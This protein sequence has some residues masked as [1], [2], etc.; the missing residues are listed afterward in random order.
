MKQR[1]G[2]MNNFENT[3][4]LCLDVRHLKTFFPVYKGS[5]FKRKMGEIKAVN[6][7]SFQIKRAK[8]M[9]M[10]GESGCGKTTVGRSILLLNRPTSGEIIYNGI[11]IMALNYQEIR[12]L[13]KKIQMVFQD[14]FGSINPRMTAGDVIGEPL[15]IHHICQT[16]YEYQKTIAELFLMVGLDPG[17]ADWYPHE[18]S[19]GQRQ[20]IVI[21]RALSVK[22][23]LLICDEPVSALDVSIQAQI[24]N[25]LEELQEKYHLTY[26]FI[27]HDLSVVKHISDTIAVMY[28][29]N[30]VEIAH[31]KEL[32]DHPRHPYTRALFSSVP[33]PDPR[34]EA[35]RKPFIIKGE[36][37]SLINPP[38]GCKF[39]P[40]CP[41]ATNDCKKN[42]PVLR[43]CA[44]DTIDKTQHWVACFLSTI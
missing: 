6:D 9:G 20:R 2:F 12:A 18:F 32:Y 14:P 31:R 26:L 19:G 39:H 5:F 16:K 10:V 44:S 7:V 34:L 27:S 8:T 35:K 38:S 43:L 29:G 15:L 28:M 1:V 24:I 4:D 33:I 25:L 41:Y 42:S 3:N 23:D 40:R 17:M 30:I 21:A 36:V 37:A 22:P 13:R 11:N